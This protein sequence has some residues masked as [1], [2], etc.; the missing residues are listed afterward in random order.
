MNLFRP[1]LH[2]NGAPKI[3]LRD[4]IQ[5]EYWGKTITTLDYPLG[6]FIN[7]NGCI[8]LPNDSIEALL[9]KE[10]SILMDDQFQKSVAKKYNAFT[11]L[12]LNEQQKLL[13]LHKEE[14]EEEND[15]ES[16]KDEQTEEEE[17]QSEEE[18]LDEGDEEDND[19]NEITEEDFSI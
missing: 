18:Q 2:A 4:K 5:E 17:S 1:T 13:D 14:E 6:V 11:L 12:K 19:L 16:E 15:E 10:K 9:A 3:S 7:K 8:D